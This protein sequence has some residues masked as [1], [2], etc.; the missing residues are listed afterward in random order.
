MN[1]KKVLPVVLFL[2]GIVLLGV[3][4][5]NGDAKIGFFLIIPVVYGSGVFS[6]LGMLCLMAGIFLYFYTRSQPVHSSR[7]GYTRSRSSGVILIGPI[8]IIWGSD[9][10]TTTYTV[11]LAIILMVVVFGLFY[12]GFFF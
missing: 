3:A 12:S 10:K 8:P 1:F 6:F 4:V 2:L 5:A 7:G 9:P 11:V